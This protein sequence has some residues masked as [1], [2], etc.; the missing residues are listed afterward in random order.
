MQ[1]KG[2]D[3]IDSEG[4]VTETVKATKIII[5]LVQDQNLFHQFRLIVSLLL[6]QVK[7]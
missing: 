1:E 7:Q 5:A 4:N 6:L 2:I 3:V